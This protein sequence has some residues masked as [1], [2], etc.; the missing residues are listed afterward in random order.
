MGYYLANNELVKAAIWQGLYSALDTEKANV[1]ESYFRLYEKMSQS[2]IH[3]AQS[4]VDELLFDAK[5]LNKDMSSF[6]KQ[7]I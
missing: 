6:P 4:K 1:N 5:W 7:L 3:A 2:Q